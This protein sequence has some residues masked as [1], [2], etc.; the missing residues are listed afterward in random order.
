MIF[1]VMYIRGIGLCA[2]CGG[3]DIIGT[4]QVIYFPLRN[5]VRIREFLICCK[6]DM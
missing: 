1:P 6:V 5:F 2:I 3:Q 4:T